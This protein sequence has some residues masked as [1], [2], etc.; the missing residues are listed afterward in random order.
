MGYS[1][2]YVSKG[3]YIQIDVIGKVNF[4]LAK[5]YS[6]EAVKLAHENRCHNF[7][8]DHKKTDPEASGIY[9][10][11]TDGAA[12]EKFGFKSTDKIA[13]IISH[14]EEDGSS[15]DNE[16]DAK[17]SN[18]RYFTTTEKALDWLDSTE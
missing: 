9:K 1:I 6:T 15:E 5:E 4:K 18:F 3:N 8:I 7:I 14:H 16:H 10:L 11:H 17:W 12:L 13:I 2:K